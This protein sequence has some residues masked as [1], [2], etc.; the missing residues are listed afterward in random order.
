[1]LQLYAAEKANRTAAS[2]KV[3]L[4]HVD[5]RHVTLRHSLAIILRRAANRIDGQA[6]APG[7]L[8]S[9]T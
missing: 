1:M 2:H 8:Q 9:V 5:R 4:H 6:T 7:Q 3:P